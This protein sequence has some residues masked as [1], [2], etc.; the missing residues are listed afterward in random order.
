MLRL[1]LPEAKKNKKLLTIHLSETQSF[2]FTNKIKAKSFKVQLENVLNDAFDNL[3]Q[4]FTQVHSIHQDIFMFIKSNFERRELSEEIIQYQK[5]LISITNTM[6]KTSVNG[7]YFIYNK[8]INLSSSLKKML[9][10][11]QS[12]AFELNNHITTKKCKSI[13]RNVMV[14]YEFLS[15]LKESVFNNKSIKEINYELRLVI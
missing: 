4:L 8:L 5:D 11:L 2:S 9:R 1:V 10:L 14:E 7:A 15:H 3:R 6:Y 12:I 13:L